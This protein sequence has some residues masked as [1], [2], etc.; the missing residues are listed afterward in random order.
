[1]IAKW[2]QGKDTLPAGTTGAR[3]REGAALVFPVERLR[4]LAA[5]IAV[6]IA[7]GA[8]GIGLA[9]HIR[10]Y[11]PYLS[12]DSLI[13][14]RYAVRLATGHGLTW[15][16]G[17]RVEGYTNLLWVL[18]NTPAT[19]LGIDPILSARALGILGVSGAVA[20]IGWSPLAGR[21]SVARIVAGGGLLVSSAP[22]AVWAIGGLEPGMVI[23]V[24]GVAIVA[25][26]RLV[27]AEYSRNTARV[28][29]F[30]LA[31]IALLRADGPLAVAVLLGATILAGFPD[32]NRFATGL[33]LV[34]PAGIAVA[35]QLAFRLVYYGEWWPNSAFVKVAF[36]MDRVQRG[37][38]YV[39]A[40]ADGGTVVLALAC[41]GTAL[42]LERRP[43]GRLLL[44]WLLSATWVS[45]IAALGADIFPAHRRLLPVLLALCLLVADGAEVLHRLVRHRILVA[46]LSLVPLGMWHVRIQN[47]DPASDHAHKDNWEFDGLAIGELLKTAFGDKRPLFAMDAA[48]A[49]AYA[50]ELPALDLLGL[51]DRHIGHHPTGAFGHGA[52]GHELGDGRYVFERQPDLVTFGCAGGTHQAVFISG[53]ELVA[54]PEFARRY[55]WI[56]LQ[57]GPPRNSYGEVW[58]RRTG[59]PLG[60]QR[61]SGRVR[62]PGYF[63][64]GET[65]ETRSRLTPDGVLAAYV[66][67]GTWAEVAGVEVPPGRWRAELTAD[68][69]PERLVVRCNGKTLDRLAPGASL[70]IDVPAQV[71]LNVAAIAPAAAPVIVRE[72]N[73]VDDRRATATHRCPVPGQPVHVAYSEL[74]TRRAR[75]S[76]SLAPTNFVLPAQPL[77][78]ELPERMYPHRLDLSVDHND[79]YLVQLLRS[80]DVVWTRLL[81]P[82][83]A[84]GLVTLSLRLPLP[85]ATA[86]VDAIRIVPQAGDGQYA[87]GHLI[88][89]P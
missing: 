35:G 65:S 9:V 13:S 42:A 3:D 62:I 70:V 31:A 37:L 25:L 78:V 47:A 15:T 1:M 82:P 19:W 45:Y 40:A 18:L 52:P 29:A 56:R 30:A 53:H 22:A 80:G 72:L 85:I 54:I 10:H 86:G 7:F 84:G 24:M 64:T 8:C 55:Q 38:D 61:E 76:A 20:A 83:T 73:L 12:D 27:C 59:G 5:K 41:L 68:G 43:R 88:L 16:D 79:R 23:G 49:L 60:I 66:Q 21:W 81:F 34:L 17:E 4:A 75:D 39:K 26:Q 50:S 87:V 11:W 63:F 14:L 2:S 74:Q 46:G 77:D 32:R 67:P 69:S 44:P 36:T 89:V 51:N 58:V 33:R 28:G 57:A 71:S 6:A 48:G